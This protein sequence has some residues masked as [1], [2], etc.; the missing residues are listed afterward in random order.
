[1]LS[2]VTATD[3]PTTRIIPN[4]TDWSLPP[5]RN[6]A[7][8]VIGASG[9]LKDGTVY[10]FLLGTTMRPVE[11]DMQELWK[12]AALA[13][14]VAFLF[15]VLAGLIAA[16]LAL[17][18]VTESMRRLEQFTGDAGHELRTPLS[19]IRLNAQV[20]LNQDQEPEEFR[21]HLTAIASQAERSTHLSESLLLLARLDREQSAPQA[22]V[23]LLDL[24]TD[25]R[26]AHVEALDAK[27]VTLQTPSEALTITANRELLTVALDN[28]VENAV[29]YAPDGTTVTITAQQTEGTVIIAVIDRGPGIP[30]EA[31]PHIWDR[32][33]RVDPSRSRE[34]G[35]NGLGLAIVRKAVEAMH[36][37][38]AVT[39]EVGKGSTFSVILPAS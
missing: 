28:L 37:H 16:S 5:G 29:R 31:L 27:S 12:A 3:T 34:S 39:S 8:R 7:V 30:A 20:A 19:S 15:I 25:L 33:T 9:R 21:R 18:P 24:W 26:S 35:G 23:Q 17:R 1:M 11:Q 4:H 2:V 10:T 32:F 13:G 38:V 14:P 22:P 6:L 36:G